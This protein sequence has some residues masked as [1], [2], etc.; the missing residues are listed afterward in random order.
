MHINQS[1]CGS[2]VGTGIVEELDSRERM[3]YI[4]FLKNVMKLLY[5]SSVASE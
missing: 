2:A 5:L 4:Y 1:H 3:V